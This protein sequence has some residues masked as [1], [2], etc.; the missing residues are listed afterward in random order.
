M[1]FWVA[2]ALELL[3]DFQQFLYYLVHNPILAIQ[4]LISLELFD[5]PLHIEE[6]LPFLAT[7]P[8]LFVPAFV[9]VA[10]PLGALGAVAGLAA[11]PPT[12]VTAPVPVVAPPVM[13]PPLLVHL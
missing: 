2:R 1:I 4:Y 11:L 5:W 10:A 6:A 8:E 13:P 3:E 12:V 7:Q 9:V